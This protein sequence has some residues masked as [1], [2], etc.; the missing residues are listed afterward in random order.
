MSDDPNVAHT[1]RRGFLS[2]TAASLTLAGAGV[3]TGGADAGVTATSKPPHGA[4]VNS[5]ALQTDP[6]YREAIIQY[7]DVIVPEGALKFDAKR[8][9]L[10]ALCRSLKARGFRFTVSAYKAISTQTIRSTDRRLSACWS[11]SDQW[12]WRLR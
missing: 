9:A 4:A 12:A 8:R 7:C 5:L 3:R 10:L 2:H 1:D 6:A 11:K